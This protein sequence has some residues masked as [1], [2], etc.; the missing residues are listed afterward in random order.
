VNRLVGA[1]VAAVLAG[2]CVEH[3]AY[4]VG[5]ATGTI[6]FGTCE[7][8]ATATDK[9]AAIGAITGVAFGVL[10]ALIFHFTDAGANHPVPDEPGDGVVPLHT[11]TPP[12][13]PP[14]PAD[15][16][17]APIAIDAGI[18]MPVDAAQG[19]AGL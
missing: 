16:G 2:S 1:A 11:F 10:T 4:T 13:P 9:C 3:P 14:L 12:P 5:I 15:A 17:V 19:D 6:G 7:A 8:D 18:V